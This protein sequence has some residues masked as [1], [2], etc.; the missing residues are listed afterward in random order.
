MKHFIMIFFVFIAACGE[1]D[2]VNIPSAEEL[3]G[4]YEVIEYFSYDNCD[5]EN[6]K[7]RH[8]DYNFIKLEEGTS[9][10]E[11]VI[12]FWLCSSGGNEHCDSAVMTG[13]FFKKSSGWYL[14]SPGR[15]FDDEF[16]TCELKLRKSWLDVHGDIL[17]IDTKMEKYSFS[18]SEDECGALDV[19]EKNR[20]NLECVNKYRYVMS[21]L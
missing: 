6:E 10:G 5:P 13:R 19:M 4:Y 1:D 12:E 16:S 18:S 9:S 2:G 21:M 15:V 20:Q 3:S 11:T 7:K 17:I 8:P 14:E